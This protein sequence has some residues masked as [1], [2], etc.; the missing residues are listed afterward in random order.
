MPSKKTRSQTKTSDIS[1]AE[2]VTVIDMA[3]GVNAE[4]SVLIRTIIREEINA[5]VDK[6]QPQ[7]DGLKTD[8]IEC[9]KKVAVLEKS[10]S[11]MESRVLDLEMDKERLHKENKDLKDRADRLENYSRKY[12]LRILGLTTD[13]EKGNPTSYM[14]ALFQELF[15]DKLQYMPEVESAH[16]TGSANKHGQRA[17]IVRMHRLAA[18]EEILRMAKMKRVLEIRGM[19][20]RIFPDFTT[21]I[22][23]A[24]A[25]FR[26][27]RSILWSV[28]VKHGII[29]PATLIL[30]FKGETKKF[31]DHLMAEKFVKT[32]IKPEK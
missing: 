7:L 25:S 15:K 21:E 18:R 1:Q 28:G 4:L 23:K 30:T 29:H 20:L 19:K 27:V 12:N 2:Q 14:S 9:T 8:L 17:M 24:R 31:A 32:V 13:I 11:C 10:V 5:A 26:E 16:R 22:A 6:L 3:E